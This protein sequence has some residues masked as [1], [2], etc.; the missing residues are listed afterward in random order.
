VKE[1]TSPVFAEKELSVLRLPGY[2]VLDTEGPLLGLPSIC[3]M[4]KDDERLLSAILH[5]VLPKDRERFRES[6]CSARL[7]I[8][9]ITGFSGSGKTQALATAIV[10][11]LLNDNI[12]AVYAS[13]ASNMGVSQMAARIDKI[14]RA[15]IA[16]YNSTAGPDRRTYPVIIRGHNRFNEVDK[17]LEYVESDRES[18]SDDGQPDSK[19]SLPL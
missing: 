9:A 17:F 2:N 6:M 1:D 10:A 13:A 3:L 5:N 11:M 7:G 19:W 18:V 8:V 15:T 12:R 16:A 14:A 4:N